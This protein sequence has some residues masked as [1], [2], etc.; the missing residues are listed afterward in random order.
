LKEEPVKKKKVVV[1]EEKRL[2]TEEAP[3]EEA[4]TTQYQNI[5]DKINWT[6]Y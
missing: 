1:S 3:A 2:K 6:D 5:G 4:I